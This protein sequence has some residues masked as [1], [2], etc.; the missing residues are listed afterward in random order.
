MPDVENGD[1]VGVQKYGQPLTLE[2][3]SGY[4]I[5]DGVSALVCGETANSELSSTEKVAACVAGGFFD[6][7]TSKCLDPHFLSNEIETKELKM[8]LNSSQAH[9]L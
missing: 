8:K 9:C 6:K 5:T 4:T 7:V 2:C 1:W 3:H